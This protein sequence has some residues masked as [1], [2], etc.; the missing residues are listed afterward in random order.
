MIKHQLLDTHT[1]WATHERKEARNAIDFETMDQLD[2]LVDEIRNNEEIRLFVFTG[3]G[4]ST[5]ISGGDLKKFHSVQSKEDA[6]EFSRRMITILNKLERLPCWTVAAINGDAYGGGIETMLAFDFRVSVDFARFG[7]TQGKFYLSPGWGGLT[8]LIDQVG[9]SKALEWLGRCEV[10]DAID[11][12]K[13]GLIN[14]IV[15]EEPFRDRVLEWAEPLLVNDRNYIQTLK[16]VHHAALDER[17]KRIE[18]EIEPFA[19]L[20]T[21]DAHFKRVEQFMSRKK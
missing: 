2:A 4:T 18:K 16:S 7:H 9:R 21:S 12:K 5:F 8:R 19:E 20:W 15:D 6:L 10:I 1:V 17:A 11:A 13:T 3:A 14:H